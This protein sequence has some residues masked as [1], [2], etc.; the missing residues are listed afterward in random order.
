MP[1]IDFSFYIIVAILSVAYP[2]IL[3][4]IN[5]IDEKVG[6]T[7]L[8]AYFKTEV[9]YKLFKFFLYSDLFIFLVFVISRFEKIKNL[10]SIS[11]FLITGV[12]VLTISLVISFFFLVKKLLKYTSKIEIVNYL[13][14]LNDKSEQ[15]NEYKYF[16]TL[17]DIF[18]W[19]IKYEVDKIPETLYKYFQSCFVRYEDKTDNTVIIYPTA[20]YNSTYRLMHELIKTN[21]QKFKII[22]N[23]VIGGEWLLGGFKDEGI[24]EESYRYLWYNLLFAV[25]SKKDDAVVQYW[26]SAFNH[27]QYSLKQVDSLWDNGKIANQ[28]EIDQ[29]DKERSRFLE[30]HY[31]LGGLLLYKKRYNCINRIFEYTNSQ[32]PEYVLFPKN[33]TEIFTQYF[34]FRNSYEREML[35]IESRYP[36]PENEGIDSSD[37]IRGWICEYIVLLAIRQYSLHEYFVYNKHVELPT[38]PTELNEQRTWLENIDYFN[39]RFYAFLNDKNLIRLIGLDFL[40]SL[41][42]EWCDK[43]NKIKPKELFDQTKKAINRNIEV[44]KKLRFYFKNKL[45]SL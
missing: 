18:C 25:K 20:Y 41:S 44:R 9:E 38:L 45:T 29:R 36:F 2:I 22:E 42:D 43:H 17:S 15:N 39:A 34:R 12:T 32:P 40:E 14:R 16:N 19:S 11:D 13:I 1:D 7:D 35:F 8:V 3:Q 5:T 21:N 23:A 27:L 6:T 31:A 4:S 24:S 28:V 10:I 37:R 33:T 26:S 30:F